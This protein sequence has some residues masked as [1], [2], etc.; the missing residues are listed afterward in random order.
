MRKFRIGDKVRITRLMSIDCNC[1]RSV[2]DVVVVTK[3]DDCEKD[4][5]DENGYTWSAS[6]VELVVKYEVGKTYI[7][8]DG[9]TY[10]IVAVGNSYQLE[11]TFS[12]WFTEKDLDNWGAKEVTDEEVRELTV[13]E[14]EKELGYKIKII[15]G[16]R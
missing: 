3:Y 7:D 2:G 10:K 13:A 6:Q 9:D 16:E 4:F 15:K 11:G 14:L 8:N 12:E 5:N 1:K